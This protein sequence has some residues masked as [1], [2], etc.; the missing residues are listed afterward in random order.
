MIYEGDNKIVDKCHGASPSMLRRRISL[1]KRI[2]LQKLSPIRSVKPLRTNHRKIELTEIA[3]ALGDSVSNRKLSIWRFLQVLI[4]LVGMFIWSALI[5]SPKLGLHL[6]WNVLIPVAPAL[7]VLAPGVWRNVCPLG[8]FSLIPHHFGFSARREL[9]SVWRGRLFLAAFLLLMLVVPL[10]KVLLDTNGHV[11]AVILAVVGLL[12]FG[13]GTFFNRKSGWCSSLCPVYP[14]ELLYGSQPLVTVQNSHCPD[15]VHCVR[16]CS[17]SSEGLSPQTAVVTDLAKNIGI[18]F[19]GIF[20]G[21]IWGWYNV[22]TY[23]GWEGFR[24]LKQAFGIPYAAGAVTLLVYLVLRK[25]WPKQ[26]QTVSHIFAASA[27]ITYYWFRLPPVFGIGDPDAAMIV[28]ISESIP[29]WSAMALQIFTVVTFSWLMVI[30]TGKRHPWE[31]HPPNSIQS[32]AHS[33]GDR[34]RLPIV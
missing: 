28:D 12:A 21:F 5:F 18:L 17:E 30:R 10:R 6:L 25:V 27:I 19:T 16:P 9:S 34:H 31:V 8:S 29:A 24:H 33:V 14:V 20:P 11:L 23:S 2:P 22:T 1:L 7:F 13:M 4:W 26:K 3:P 32:N 15:C